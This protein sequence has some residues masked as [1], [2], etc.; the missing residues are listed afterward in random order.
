MRSHQRTR[1]AAL[2]LAAAALAGLQA[3]AGNPWWPMLLFFGTMAAVMS[4]TLLIMEAEA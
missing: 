4:S 3:W 1:L 2:G